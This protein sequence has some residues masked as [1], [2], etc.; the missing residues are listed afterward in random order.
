MERRSLTQPR[1]DFNQETG[2]EIAWVS[3]NRLELLQLEL[4]L[5]EE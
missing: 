2:L 4:S 3:T 1:Q 5:L